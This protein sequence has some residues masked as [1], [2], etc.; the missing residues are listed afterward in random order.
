MTAE[1]FPEPNAPSHVKGFSC[2]VL[3][4][5]FLVIRVQSIWEGGF[6][7][8]IYTFPNESN[9]VWFWDAAFEIKVCPWTATHV[10]GNSHND[11]ESKWAQSGQSGLPSKSSRPTACHSNGMTSMEHWDQWLLCEMRGVCG[12]ACGKLSLSHLEDWT[13]VTLRCCSGG[14]VIVR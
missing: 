5:L 4:Y 13:M 6:F 2:C 9:T 11:T 10:Q 1:L 7:T 14:M 3:S 12:V 8:H